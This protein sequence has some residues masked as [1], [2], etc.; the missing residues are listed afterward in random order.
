ML[1][2]EFFHPMSC[3]RVVAVTIDML[4]KDLLPGREQK[5]HLFVERRFCICFSGFQYLQ[6][7]QSSAYKYD[8]KDMQAGVTLSLFIGNFHHSVHVEVFTVYNSKDCNFFFFF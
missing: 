5:K 8:N 2:E 6:R 7:A 1:H 4:V 3:Q